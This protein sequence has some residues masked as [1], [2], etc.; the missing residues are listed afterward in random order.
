ME[1]KEDYTMATVFSKKDFDFSVIYKLTSPSGKIYVGQTQC[2][3]LR[4]RD[5]RKI[6]TNPY[7]K[8]AILKYG[9]KNIKVE[10]LE[11][12]IDFNKLDKKEQHYF[13]TLKPFGNNGYNI[14]RQASTTRGR[15][16]PIS[17]MKGISDFNKT[18]VGELNPFYG[19]KHSKESLAKMSKAKKGKRLS[20][21]IID[22]IAE[23]GVKCVRQIDPVTKEV[24]A[25]FR[26]V[27][28]ASVKF[29]LNPTGISNVASSIDKIKDDTTPIT[30]S[31]AG[32]LWVFC[33]TEIPKGEVLIGKSSIYRGVKQVD[34]ITGETVAEFKSLTI[35]SFATNISISTISN[36]AR[37]RTYTKN[38]KTYTYKSAGGYFWEYINI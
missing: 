21:E 13:D 11:K 8:S 36:V 33:D 5:Y 1:T 30:K 22:K 35:A 27:L 18:R 24:I 3:Y 14:C 25:E 9:L 19:K 4:F 17:E 2:M 31:A 23:S 32:F 16:R 20:K 7:L 29:G 38:G 26:S 10:I 28:E 34:L 37:K 12:D 15:K 6:R